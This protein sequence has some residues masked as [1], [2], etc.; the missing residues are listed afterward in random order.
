[1]SAVVVKILEPCHFEQS[2][3]VPK[4]AIQK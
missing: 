1:M 2:E 4:S 3:P